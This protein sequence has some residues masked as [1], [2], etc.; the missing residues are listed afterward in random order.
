[1]RCQLL[2]QLGLAVRRSS[3]DNIDF[4]EWRGAIAVVEQPIAKCSA[5][6]RRTADLA[7][8]DVADCQVRLILMSFV[9]SHFLQTS[10]RSSN[11]PTDRIGLIRTMTISVPQTGHVDEAPASGGISWPATSSP[12]AEARQRKPDRQP[13]SPSNQGITLTNLIERDETL[14]TFVPEHQPH[15]AETLD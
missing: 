9:K 15:A 14:L 13:H 12:L 7:W 5:T 4:D 6:R 10:V 1:M 3:R 2:T 11:S 8:L